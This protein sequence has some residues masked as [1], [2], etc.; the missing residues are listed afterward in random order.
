MTVRDRDHDLALHL[1]TDDRIE[2][3][4]LVGVVDRAIAG[5]ATIVQLRDKRATAREL[6]ERV[7]ALTDVVDGRVPVVVDDRLDVVL[8]ARDAGARVDG[9][10]LGQS[11]IPPLAAR[12]LLGRDA[13]VGWTANEPAHLAAAAAMPSGTLD[14]LGVGVIRP[15]TTKP[16]HPPALGIDGF[17][18]LAAATALPC[19]AIGGVAPGDVAPL[20]AA[21]AAGVAVVSAICGAMDPAAAA[22]S[23]RTAAPAAEVLR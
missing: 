18:R 22:R 9:V 6:L 5:G 21:G 4:V 11:D 10:H 7:I 15:T 23:F 3:D 14:Y 19:V 2:F 20:R 12:R 8:A 16:D 13:I 17:A 1:V